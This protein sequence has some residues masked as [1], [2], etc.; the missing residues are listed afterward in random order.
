MSK[1]KWRQP[2]SFHLRE[3][4]QTTLANK[5]LVVFYTGKTTAIK[6]IAL[7]ETGV[8]S[9]HG[10]PIEDNPW[11]PL[12]YQSYKGDIKKF[13]GVLNCTLIMP[14]DAS[15]S[16]SGCN[17]SSQ[18]GRVAL[19]CRDIFKLVE[20]RSLRNGPNRILECELLQPNINTDI[21]V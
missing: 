15:L 7:R 16:D 13:K 4:L 18:G 14:R 1:F 11:S 17:F 2:I 19:V 3:P 8:S 10:G 20:I 9:H 6:C 12:D 21:S 5:S